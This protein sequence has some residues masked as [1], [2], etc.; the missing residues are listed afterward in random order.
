MEKKISSPVTVGIV[1]S[2]ILVVFTVVTYLTGLYTQSWAQY[3]GLVILFVGVFWAVLNHGKEKNHEVTFGNLFAFGFK[4]AA[5][6]ACIV[7]IY[8][9]LSGYIF[10]DMKDKFI[11]IAKQKALQ[12]PNA[13]A[14]QVEKGMEMFAKNYNLFIIIGII[15]WYLI[16]GIVTSLI[17]AAVAKKNP[18]APFDQS[19]K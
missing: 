9:I 5:V 19:F 15:F 13:N 16:I 6:A 8:S 4:V 17:A 2:L 12:N 3:A 18:A 14:E 10:P 1:L 11:E 7:I